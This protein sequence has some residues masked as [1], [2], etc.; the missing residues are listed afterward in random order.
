[1]SHKME[2]IYLQV[3]FDLITAKYLLENNVSNETNRIL[4]TLLETLMKLL[5]VTIQYVTFFNWEI[6]IEIDTGRFFDKGREFKSYKQIKDMIKKI[7][8]NI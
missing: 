2:E 6:E 8:K 4:K 3:L 5:F 1:M 7:M